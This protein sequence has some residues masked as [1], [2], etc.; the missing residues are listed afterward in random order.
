MFR[1][2]QTGK[3][4]TMRY[5]GLAHRISVARLHEVLADTNHQLVYETSEHMC[6]D[7]Y[8][9]GFPDKAKWIAAC[10]LICIVDPARLRQLVKPRVVAST[11]S[12]SLG[13]GGISLSHA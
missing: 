5:L 9:K 12:S 2:V 3:N 4:P 8:T 10:D 1:V 6:A 11:S 13:R 7:I